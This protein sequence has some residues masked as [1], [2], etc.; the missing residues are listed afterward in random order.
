M[1]NKKKKKTDLNLNGSRFRGLV[2]ANNCTDCQNLFWN[3]KVCGSDRRIWFC[4]GD[5][6]VMVR[7]WFGSE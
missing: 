5:D 7:D 2:S 6:S 3:L 1:I 4:F